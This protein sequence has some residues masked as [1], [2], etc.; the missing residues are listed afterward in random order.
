MLSSIEAFRGSPYTLPLGRSSCAF[1]APLRIC[2]RTG[3]D[4][5]WNGTPLMLKG[6]LLPLFYQRVSSYSH[7][8][9]TKWDVR[10]P[11]RD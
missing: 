8:H 4:G 3:T 2:K 1:L 11:T 7:M 9:C 10:S 6:V 5:D